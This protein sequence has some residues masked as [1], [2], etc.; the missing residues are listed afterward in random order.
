MPKA[1]PIKSLLENT[2]FIWMGLIFILTVSG[3]SLILPEWMQVIGRTHPLLL[4]FPI[5]LLLMG[6][7]IFWLPSLD[8]KPDI[9]E[10]G[11][12]SLLAGSNFAGITVIAGLLLAQ[13]EYD[14]DSLSW[15]QWSGTA[16]FYLSAAIYFYR[17]KRTQ[18]IRPLTLLL[19]TGI[20]ATGHWGANLTHGDDFLLAPILGKEEKTVSLTEA[21]VFTDL[22]QPILQ[23]KCESCHKA[24]K[25]KGDLRLDSPEALIKGGKSGALIAEGDL[26]SSLLLKRINLPSD[27][28]KH[29]PP[30]N[31]TQLSE[32]EMLILK[33][34]VANGASFDQRVTETDPEGELLR[35]AKNRFEAHPSYSF[36]SADYEDIHQLNNF[37]RS[38]KPLYPG[39]AALEVSYFGIS[40]FD[41]A[42][43]SE[44][45]TVKNQ[46]VKLNLNKMPLADADLGFLRELK[47]LE[48]LQLNFTAVTGN[49]LSLISELTQLNNLAV[50]GNAIDKESLA[51]L[52]KMKH[53]D[54]LYLWQTGLDEHEKTSLTS[55]LSSTAI[56]FGYDGKGIVYELNPPKIAHGDL[57]FK[58]SMEVTL[59][60]PIKTAEIRYTLNGSEPDSISS[61]VYSGPIWVK[62]TGRITAKVF[63]ADWKGSPKNES[64]VIKSGWKPKA[65]VLLTSPNERYKSKGAE[66]LFDQVKGKNEHSSGEWLGYQDDP[67]E[68]ELEPG[69]PAVES[70]TISLLLNENAHIFPPSRIELSGLIDGKW[71]KLKSP[72]INPS[73]ESEGARFEVIQQNLGNQPIQKLRIKIVTLP[74]LPKWHASAGSKGWVFVDE[75]IL[76]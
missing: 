63:A 31:K 37:F 61:A 6:I 27:D 68:L 47:N 70:I 58:D 25:V 50:S 55:S 64:L 32:E 75:I 21:E 33:E 67:L 29:M 15:H 76:N 39:S 56:D 36:A 69:M 4:H 74:S 17:A 45:T 73:E 1:K 30:K 28:K 60:H 40:A 12:F 46:I 54:K 71:N 18:L 51:E 23:T 20:I 66:T 3:N 14:G 19:V 11:E 26:G 9:R 10:A 62:N 52:A 42:S 13:E 48:E 41:P 44:L 8:Q 5:V 72:Q 57:L 22:V 34:W 7:M 24:G 43:L 2:L 16:V 35:L 65:Y 59:S 49:H 53:L 38:V